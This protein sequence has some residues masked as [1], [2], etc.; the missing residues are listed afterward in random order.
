MTSNLLIYSVPFLVALLIIVFVHELGHFLVARWCGVRVT[1]FSIGFGPQ[2]TSWNDR[3]GTR[4]KLCWIPL[5]GYVKFEGDTNATSL[6]Q[7]GPP[8][9]ASPTNFHGKPL[10]Q[11]AAVVIAGPL[12]NFILAIALLTGMFATVGEYVTAPRIGEILPDSAAAAAGLQ[13]GDVILAI[14]GEEI[15]AF[16]DIRRTIGSG[17]GSPVV[18][19]IKRGDT[20]VDLNI[21]PKM[22]EVEDVLGGKVPIGQLGIKPAPEDAS[23]ARTVYPLHRAASLAVERTYF[24]MTSTLRYVGRLFSGRDTT[25]QITGISGMAKLT[26]EAARDGLAS[27]IGII[28]LISVSIGFINLFP[29]PMLDGGHL[30]FY[31]VE[32][33]R[34]RPLGPAAQEWAFKIGLTSV[35][36]LM[37]VGNFNDIVKIIGQMTKG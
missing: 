35:L 8:A 18:L 30:M 2:I 15:V 22:A 34:G 4:W 19:S 27:F 14:D 13:K 12:A 37:F 17:G 32:A 21:T 31:L 7:G 10:W 28:A 9:P 16:E 11:R 25:K 24:V 33:V 36:L 5:G 26:G 23:R 3:K 1:D 29:I 20:L 6:P